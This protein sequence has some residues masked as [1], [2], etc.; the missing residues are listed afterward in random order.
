[1]TIH[2]TAATRFDIIMLFSIEIL[3][4]ATKTA[5]TYLLKLAGTDYELP[6]VD[7]IVSKH[8]GTV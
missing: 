8:V 1:M 2:Y 5:F 3:N 7:T 6:E 4:C